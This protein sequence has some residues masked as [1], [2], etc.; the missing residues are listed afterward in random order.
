MSPRDARPA[1]TPARMLEKRPAKCSTPFALT[2]ERL[3]KFLLIL[4]QERLFIAASALQHAAATDTLK[5]RVS[6]AHLL[7]L[8]FL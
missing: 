2:A 3:V 6:T 8:F 4:P 1:G 5:K 7:F